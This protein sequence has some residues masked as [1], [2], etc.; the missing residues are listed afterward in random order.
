MKKIIAMILSLAMLLCA[1]SAMAEESSEKV[2]IGTLNVNGN[3]TLQCGMPE[4]YRISESSEKQFAEDY[5]TGDDLTLSFVSDDP[6]APVMQL[7]IVH[8]EMYADVERMNDLDD[9]A[10]AILEESF[11]ENDPDVELS[12]TETGYGTLL[13]VARFAEEMQNAVV[14]F[15][16]Y[17][18]YDIEFALVPSMTAET[19]ELTEEQIALSIAF[20]T[21][22]DFIPGVVREFTPQMVAEQMY[23]TNLSDYDPESDTVSAQVMHG[24]P[25]PEAQAEALQVGDKLVAGQFEEEIETLEK[26]EDGDILINDDIRLQKFGD[27]YHVFIYELEWLEPYGTLRLQIPDTLIVT[28]NVDSAT[29]EPLEEPVTYTVDEFRA[30]LAAEASPDF[31]TDNT[32]VT[33]DE[34]GEMA[35]VERVYSPAQ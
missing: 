5:Y 10:L 28:D 34:N 11:I 1:V 12:F 17:K 13:L 33:F 20:L 2:T 29:G 27:E 14:F 8:D 18:G 22:L 23:I 30:M 25:L 19:R 32:W 4:G 26:T 6:N 21:D 7:S 15:S 9:E 3:F 16:I 35:A 31:A 24:V